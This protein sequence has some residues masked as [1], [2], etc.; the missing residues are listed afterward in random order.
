MDVIELPQ[1]SAFGPGSELWVLP[2]PQTCLWARQVDWYV[3]GLIS[4]AENRTPKEIAVGLR[5][6]LSDEEISV[7]EV[8]A[9]EGVLLIAAASFAPTKYILIQQYSGGLKTWLKKAF[10]YAQALNLEKT[11]LFLPDKG[12]LPELKGA[13]TEFQTQSQVMIVGPKSGGH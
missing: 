13:L 4:R 3:N 7:P 2:D 11:R 9:H 5:K 12:S 6:I 10:H 1:V 8:P